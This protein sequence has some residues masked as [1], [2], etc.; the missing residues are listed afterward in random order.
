MRL[1]R[2]DRR[3]IGNQ[4]DSYRRGIVLGLTMAEVG[5]L[6]IFVLLL[7][8]VVGEQRR[9]ELQRRGRDERKWLAEMAQVLGVTLDAS[10]DDFRKL[11]LVRALLSKPDV[12]AALI[13]AREA[14]ME[15]KRAAEE[16]RRA[17]G[18]AVGGGADSVARQIEQQ[19][20]RQ[21]NQEGQLKVLDRRLQAAGQ[22]KG[23]R[24]CWAQ[25]DGTIDYL[26][27]VAL[28]SKGIRLRE[29]IYLKREKERKLLPAPTVDPG[30]AMSEATLIG[31][32]T[33][34]FEQ[35]Q[36]NNCRFFVVVFDGTAADEKQLYKSQLKAVEGHFYKRLDSGAPPF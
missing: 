23:E 1:P 33:A 13:E 32:T 6:I 8:L 36:R 27:D 12:A 21:A 25:P 31:R 9:F 4:N 34:L 30:E 17:V 10:P 3:R 22:G 18:A 24:P 28:T 29:R 2:I 16:M 35:S 26:Y 14:A 19:S 11:V 5:I 20:Y 7:L 15:A